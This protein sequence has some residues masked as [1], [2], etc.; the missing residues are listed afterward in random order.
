MFWGGIIA[1]A[2]GT[3]A[4][5]LAEVRE[6]R[7][8]QLALKPLLAASFLATL[9]LTGGATSSL[10]GHLILPALLACALGDVLL[11]R[12]GTGPAFIAGMG[13]FGLGHLIFVIAFAIVSG[14]PTSAIP[15]WLAVALI[16]LPAFIAW[17][18]A[19]QSQSEIMSV[20]VALY[21]I[22]I[23][24]MI[25]LAGASGTWLVLP[26]LAFAVSDLFVAQNRFATPKPWHPVVITPLYFGAQLAFALS[27]LLLSA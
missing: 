13:A 24:G 17:R 16:F 23:G 21:G 19:R 7:R 12:K 5:T 15:G 4:L 20:V 26:A 11:L 1:Y 3:A 22:A 25:A 14:E 10:Y 8:W 2:L 6:D 9:V 18:I 27:P